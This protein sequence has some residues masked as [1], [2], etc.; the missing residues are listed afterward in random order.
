MPGFDPSSLATDPS[1]DQNQTPPDPTQQLEQQTVSNI[2]GAHPQQPNPN[3]QQQQ[4]PDQGPPQP[5]QMPRPQGGMIKQ[6]LTNFFSGAGDS[7]MHH[8]GL[9]TPY[10]QAQTDYRDK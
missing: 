3:Q 7:M 5:P 8:V 2:Q 10:E 4:T 9:Q 6:F 1:Q